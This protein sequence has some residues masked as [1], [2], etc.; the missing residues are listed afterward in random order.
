MIKFLYFIFVSILSIGSSAQASSNGLAFL[1]VGVGGRAVGMGGAYT[2]LANDATAP[3]WNPAGLTQLLSSSEYIFMHNEWWPGIRMEYVGAGVRKSSWAYGWGLYWNHVSEIE[4]RLTATPQPLSIFD[5]YDALM[6]HSLAWPMFKGFVGGTLKLI[7]TKN[8]IDEAWGMAGDLGYLAQTP[9]KDLWVGAVLQNIGKTTALRN[10]SIP[11]TKVFKVGSQ[12][13]MEV[14]RLRAQITTAVDLVQYD[15]IPVQ[16]YSGIEIGGRAG[17]LRVGYQWGHPGEPQG[18]SL[19]VGLAVPYLQMDYAYVPFKYD[20]GD[21]HRI[22]ISLLTGS[23][24]ND[25]GKKN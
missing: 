5:A 25:A 22:S 16:L 8:F 2:A 23:K 1:K 4:H 13:R 12:Y 21:T 19:G 9:I 3:F 17:S 20:L 24:E 15:F 6:C 7:Y 14:P 10:Q 18:V 11:L